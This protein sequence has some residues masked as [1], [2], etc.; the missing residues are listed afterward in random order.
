MQARL[1]KTR[2]KRWKR[3]MFEERFRASY[4]FLLLRARDDASLQPLCEFWTTAQQG[5]EIP[6]A[7]PMEARR[8]RPRRRSRRR[9]PT[10]G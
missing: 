4:D 9:A 8:I 10:T 3:L 2:G 5:V 6:A 1:A 7:K